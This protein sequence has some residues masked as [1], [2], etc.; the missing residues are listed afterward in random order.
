ML[1][2][3]GV[4]NN[5]VPTLRATV[6]RGGTAVVS[7]LL[8]TYTSSSVGFSMFKLRTVYT[9]NC[10][11]V[12][13][14][15]DNTTTNI[16]FVNNYL[17]TA[18]LLAFVGSGNGFV[19]T[20]Y[21]QSGN[22]NNL[23]QTASASYQP[24]IV[25]SGSLITRN[26]IAT[27][28]A[29]NSQYLSLTTNITG[30]NSR[31]WWF[32]YEKDTTGNQAILGLN[33]GTY[34]YLDYGASQY[35]GDADYVSISP[36]LSINTF[37][38]ISWVYAPNP[39]GFKMYSNGSNIGSNTGPTNTMTL[40]RVPMSTARTTSVYFNELVYWQNDQTSNR[41]AIETDIKTRNLIY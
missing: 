24:Q 10:L 4:L 27:M 1:Y 35:C 37:R 3:Y 26:G 40:G 32:S 39:I 14:S 15:S 9:G 13:R 33:S 38:L 30:T 29:T 7:L 16:G 8:D 21:D 17:D 41:S 12:R 25:A 20:W 28:K 19:R 18:S 31:S 11:E 23:T 34:M 36:S 22:G 5:H 2:G 6:M